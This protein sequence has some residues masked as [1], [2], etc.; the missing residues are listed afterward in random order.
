MRC[1]ATL[2]VLLAACASQPA[3]WVDVEREPQPRAEAPPPPVARSAG[4]EIVVCGQRVSIGAPVVLW[5][6]PGGYDAYSQELHFGGDVKNPPEGLRYRPGREGPWGRVTRDDTPEELGRAVDQFVIHYDV[7]GTSRR[8][9][10]VLHDLRGLS[11]HFLLDLDG[12]LYQTLDLAE[13]AWHARQANP[14]SIGIEI[15]NIGAYPVGRPSPLD[16]WYVDDGRGLRIRLPESQAADNGGQR[17]AD[18]RGRPVRPHRVRGRIQDQELE[19]VDLT[20]EQY[21]T[22][23]RLTAA[24][25]DLFPQL[26][27]EVPR[28]ARGRV[29]T[30]VL[31]EA[32]YET[33]QG[34]LG[35]YHVSAN[36]TDP[37]PAFDWESFLRRVA[38]ER[39]QP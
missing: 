8:C 36:K 33:F 38:R 2:A 3:T 9:F 20:P 12:T 23:V 15:A 28:D 18:F 21:L 35:H 34:I 37:G 39:S 11:V 27:P 16:E 17:V 1:A 6:D 31:P 26:E 24:L 25:C 4:D 32:E 19:M 7:C 5:T 30:A 29:K 13:T 10:E 22:L 14:R